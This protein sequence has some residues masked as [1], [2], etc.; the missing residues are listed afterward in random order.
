MGGPAT[1]LG[2]PLE[3]LR[4]GS[5]R[6]N[7]RCD[8]RRGDVKTRRPGSRRASNGAL[9]VLLAAL[10][11][12]TVHVSPARGTFPGGNG[13]IAYAY[14]DPEPQV[15]AAY[16]A[17]MTPDGQYLD[18]TLRGYVP[19]RYAPSFSPDG[20]QLAYDGAGRALASIGVTSVPPKREALLTRPRGENY[21][22]NA[23]WSPHGMS[24]AFERYVARR[25][26]RFIYTKRVGDGALHLVA[27]GEDPAW[28]VRGEIAF[29]RYVRDR[30]SIRVIGASGGEIRTI[31]QGADAYSP[32]WSPDGSRVAFGQRGQ[33]FTVGADG[34][35]LAQL[36]VGRPRSSSPAFSPDGQSIVFA[37]GAKYLAISP[38]AGG[39]LRM[40]RCEERFCQ[41]PDCQPLPALP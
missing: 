36:T 22:A 27:R 28:S 39:P 21:D 15:D 2:P 25:R 4:A 18:W 31:T 8:A 12:A 19:Q 1:L 29:V 7:V 23:H 35:G 33:I 32:S 37:R 40:L 3:S 17:F 30:A 16:L 6:T 20:R 24:I 13:V 34:T 41:V 26:D 9:L 38:I 14:P 10:L 5:C 11:V